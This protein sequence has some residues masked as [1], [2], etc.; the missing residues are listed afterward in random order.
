MSVRGFSTATVWGASFTK[1]KAYEVSGRVD[2]SPHARSLEGAVPPP[3][4]PLV[5]HAPHHHYRLTP[6]HTTTNS[7]NRQHPTLQ[8]GDDIFVE[9]STCKGGGCKYA[10]NVG[11][12]LLNGLCIVLSVVALL[13][14]INVEL[15]PYLERRKWEKEEAGKFYITREQYDLVNDQL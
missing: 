13:Y 1:C 6:F 8:A 2:I 15:L 11:H 9:G 3:P 4:P 14:V 10:W 12:A 5:H 7:L